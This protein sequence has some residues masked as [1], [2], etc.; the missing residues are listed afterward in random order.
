MLAPAVMLAVA[1]LQ[2]AATDPS[3]EQKS[4]GFAVVEFL[5]GCMLPLS[6]HDTPAEYASASDYTGRGLNGHLGPGIAGVTMDSADGHGCRVRYQGAQGSLV[7]DKYAELVRPS[8]GP[9]GK[10]EDG[11]VLSQD[12]SNRLTG[13]CSQTSDGQNGRP[14]ITRRGDFV[15]ERSGDGTTGVTTASILNTRP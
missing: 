7:W 5:I 14:I 10:G 15:V 13:V 1:A 4:A 3:P 2:V 8:G 9:P 6:A 12:T 11:C